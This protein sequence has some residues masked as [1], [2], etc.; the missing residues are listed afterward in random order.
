MN[1]LCLLRVSTL[2]RLNSR[3]GNLIPGRF[4]V[5]FGIKFLPVTFLTGKL[6]F[7]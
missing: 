6:L 3:P 2:E 4:V 1:F 5:L 7:C